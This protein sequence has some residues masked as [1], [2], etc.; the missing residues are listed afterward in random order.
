MAIMEFGMRL[1]LAQSMQYDKRINDLRYQDQMKQQAT[2]KAEAKA[3]MFA[4]DFDYNNAMNE[5]DNPL[6]KE[7]AKAKIKQIGNFVNSNPDWETN[8]EKRAMYKQL[9]RE[10]KDNKDLNR[11]IQSDENYAQYQKDLAEKSKN[12]DLYDKEAYDNILLEWRNYEKYGNQHGEEAAAKFG[13]KAFI[14]EQP[15]DWTDLDK[16]GLEYGSKFNDFEIQ[17]VKGGGFGAYKE[18]PRE[19]SLNTLSIDFYKRNQRQMDANYQA[20]G[21]SSGLEYAKEL[22]RP[23]IK[24]KIDFGEQWRLPSGRSGSG[25]LEGNSGVWSKDVVNKEASYVN[26][27]LLK[28]AL[29]AT[30]AFKVKNKDGSQILDMT[31]SK[32]QYTGRNAYFDNNQRKGIKHFEVITRLT[33]EEAQA[34]GI[35]TNNYLFDDE[36]EETWGEKAFLKTEENKKGDNIDYVEVRDFIPIDVNS[37][38]AAG[39]YDKKATTSKFVE[40]PEYD[41]QEREQRFVDEAGNIF[42]AQGNF[43]RKQ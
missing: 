27:E 33:P 7:F 21:Y 36:I 40:Q 17:G 28:N 23:G 14:Y 15:Q 19:E 41:Y 26:G 29:G 30:P 39:I 10:L 11:G 31:G 35:L 24:T 4:D 6:V 13:K 34:K 18:V 5:H 9:V 16:K 2:I 43:I 25:G 38:T 1:G 37:P 32:V 12:P 20:L 8:V 3:K 22:I 42:D